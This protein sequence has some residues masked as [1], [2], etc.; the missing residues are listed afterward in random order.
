[1]QEIYR[2]VE[3]IAFY[4]V[5]L[6]L[7]M[8]V[9]PAGE[10]KKYIR[11]FMGLL[12]ML[13]VFGPILR[14]TGQEQQVTDL[15]LRTGYDQELEEFL[16]EQKRLER[17]MEAYTQELLEEAARKGREEAEEVRS[18]EAGS[19]KTGQEEA[20]EVRSGEAG[21]GKTGQEEAEEVRDGKLENGESGREQT[22]N[23]G[24]EDGNQEG[25]AVEPVE[26]RVRL[27]TEP[28]S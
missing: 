19:G 21:S 20:E 17:D 15:F 24:E 5:L 25:V 6:V 28:A 11:F 12:F 16:Q 22:G 23:R 13:L 4:S 2:W 1:M 14:W 10:Q 3:D 26:I 18:G 9:L 8:H 7:V 27:D